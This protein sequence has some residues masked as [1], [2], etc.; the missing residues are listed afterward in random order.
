LIRCKGSLFD[1]N[2]VD[3]F[4]GILEDCAY[5]LESVPKTDAG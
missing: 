1:P 5:D 2:I 3:I 4:I